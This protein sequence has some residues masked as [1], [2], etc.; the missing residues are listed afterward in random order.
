MCKSSQT[1]TLYARYPVFIWMGLVTV[2]TR[3]L[4]VQV[5]ASFSDVKPGSVCFSL[6]PLELVSGFASFGFCPHATSLFALD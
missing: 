4:Y 1:K 3:M 6:S 2:L 5:V